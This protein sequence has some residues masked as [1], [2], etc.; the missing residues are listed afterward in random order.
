MVCH[1]PMAWLIR[2]TLA[3]KGLRLCRGYAMRHITFSADDLRAIAW[4]RY[5]H[6]DP[7]VQRKMTV[8]WLKHQDLPHHDIAVLADVS[9]RS[10]QRYLAECLQG[11]LPRIRQANWVSP[12]STLDQHRQ[13]LEEHYRQ[14]PPHSVKQARQVIEQHAGV[15]RGLTQVRRFLHRVGLSARKV[16]AVPLPPKSTPEEH[17]RAQR[18]FLDEELEPLLAQARAGRREVYLV[19]GAHFLY[20]TVLG[21]VW[22]WV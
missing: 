17:T 9:R 22:C 6:P 18:R 11:G 4:E 21:W 20:A 1:F 7:R 19:D 8:L 14:H 12:T 16:A 13:S 15:R 2:K 5:H 10:V 3:S